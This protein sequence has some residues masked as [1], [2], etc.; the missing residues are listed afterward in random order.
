MLDGNVLTAVRRS[1]KLTYPRFLIR[2]LLIAVMIAV[3]FGLLFVLKESEE[4]STR[5]S[6]TAIAVNDA[7]PMSDGKDVATVVYTYR[8]ERHEVGATVNSKTIAGDSVEVWVDAETGTERGPTAAI[9][10]IIG[11][12]VFISFLICAVVGMCSLFFLDYFE[13]N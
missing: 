13:D 5:A 6:V 10:E 12:L 4:A 2:L 11:F 1:R 7:E 9:G 3:S 8:G